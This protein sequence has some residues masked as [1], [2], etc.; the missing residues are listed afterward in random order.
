[1]KPEVLRRAFPLLGDGIFVL[2][3]DLVA[4]LTAPLADHRR[5]RAERL[6]PGDDR[7][8]GAGLVSFASTVDDP[9]AI[10]CDRIAVDADR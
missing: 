9:M 5:Y 3:P 2:L 6:P 1:M 7:V 10:P 8:D 4:A